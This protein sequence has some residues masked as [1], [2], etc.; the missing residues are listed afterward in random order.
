MQLRISPI[1][2]RTIASQQQSA[3]LPGRNIHH[4]LLLMSEMLHCA[5]ESGEPHILLKLDVWKAFDRLEWPFL[6]AIFEK[7]GMGGTLSSFLKASLNSASSS[8]ILNGRVTQAF[9]LTRSVCQGYP[10]SSSFWPLL[11]SVAC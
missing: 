2:Q 5:K 9:R 11:L 7:S 4:A 6:L 1:L 3:F 10:L 8:I